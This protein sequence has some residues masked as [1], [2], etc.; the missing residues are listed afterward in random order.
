MYAAN[1]AT[2]LGHLAELP[3]LDCEDARAAASLALRR[4][5]RRPGMLLGAAVVDARGELVGACATG[6]GRPLVVGRHA[7]CDLRL[8]EDGLPL[9]HL[10]LLPRPGRDGVRADCWELR[11]ELPL[12]TVTGHAVGSLRGIGDFCATFGSYVLVVQLAKPEP[13]LELPQLR[14]P[15]E[16][17]PA[18]TRVEPVGYLGERLTGGRVV[19]E[20]EALVDGAAPER[21]PLTRDELRAGV[22]IGRYPR[23]ALQARDDERLSRVHLLLVEVDGEVLAIDCASSNGTRLN[24]LPLDAA[25]LHHGDV[26]RCGRMSLRWRVAGA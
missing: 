17:E 3:H 6:K 1:E 4:L 14:A 22:L 13:R 2:R 10:V 12:H 15:G 26:L 21:I 19:A 9:R 24:Q 5:L 16:P 18:V 11:S 7:Q 8:D 25:A 23:C 20:L